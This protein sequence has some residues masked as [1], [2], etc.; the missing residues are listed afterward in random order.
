MRGRQH[1]AVAADDGAAFL[2]ERRDFKLNAGLLAEGD[3]F[4]L[5]HFSCHGEGVSEADFVVAA[6]LPVFCGI[7][8]VDAVYILDEPAARIELLG[9]EQRRK[10]GTAA[11]KQCDMAVAIAGNEAGNHRNLALAQYFVNRRGVGADRL[12][13]VGIGFAQ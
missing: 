3:G 2:S 12:S 13:V 1:R 4:R 6:S 8:A 5:N 10:I 7:A 9:Q 11:S